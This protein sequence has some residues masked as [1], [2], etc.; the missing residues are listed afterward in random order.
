MI[1]C[2]AM[3][4]K[5]ASRASVVKAIIRRNNNDRMVPML[6][7]VRDV[8]RLRNLYGL[9]YRVVFAMHMVEMAQKRLDKASELVLANAIDFMNAGCGILF[10]SGATPRDAKVGIVLVQ[11]AIELMAKY[12]LVRERGLGAIVRG[13]PPEG[14]LIAAAVSGSLKTIGYGECL[15][16]I[17]ENETFTETDRELVAR[18]QQ[19]RNSLVHFTAKVDV[20][21]V[22]MD[23]AWILIRV[24][25]MFAAGQERDQGEVRNYARFLDPGNF[26][27]L[28]SFEPYRAEAVDSALDSLDSE[29]V[30]R[31]WECGVDALSVRPS[32]TYFCHCCGLTADLGMAAFTACTLCGNDDGVYFDPLNAVRGV[33][34]GRCLHC[35]T[36]V[37]V[38]VCDSCGTMRS[39]AEGLPALACTECADA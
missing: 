13:T 24:L 11:T 39:Q 25:G 1:S 34:H 37:G 7:G 36:F 21:A 9:C 2:M 3:S 31:C 15:T 26:K 38:V 29:A 16:A 14:D 10:A 6:P 30:F 35:E 20:E 8:E 19:L 23:V 28:T 32:E 33:H 27:R 17:Q 22:R 4:A 18:V 12:R 5:S